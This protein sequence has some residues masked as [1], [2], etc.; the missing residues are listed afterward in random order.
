MTTEKGKTMIDRRSLFTAAAATVAV[1]STL[2]A[3]SAK[4]ASAAYDIEPRGA[5]GR[6]ERMPYLD[7]E[8]VHDYTAGVR[9]WHNQNISRAANARVKEI[10]KENGIDPSDTNLSVQ[11]VLALIEHDPIVAMSGRIWISNQQITWKAIADRFHADADKYLAEMESYDAIGPGTLEL[12]PDL[13]IPEFAKHQIHIQPGGYQGD[14]FAGHIYHIGT[15][16]FYHGAFPG[17][18]DQDQ[19]HAMATNN[20]PVP[21]DGKVK[22]ILDLGCGIGQQAVALKER[23]PNA[24]VWGLDVSGPMIR[25]G[26]MKAVDLGV[27]VN[28]VQRLAEDTKFPDNHFDIVSS[29]IMHH[30][31][32]AEITKAVFRE[33]HRITRPGGY[34]YPIDFRSA[35]Q[36][37]KRTA[38]RIYRSWWDHRWNNERWIMEFKSVAFEEEMEKVGFVLNPDAKPAIRGFGIR[39]GVKPA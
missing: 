21:D 39:H 14:P 2:G 31:L 34:Y 25:Y 4:A 24:E 7:L 28:F 12:N 22:R 20:L 10:F 15:N 37:P 23:F 18:N 30:E 11:E 35:R 26:H 3:G 36:A 9:S 38:Y 27:D 13:L 29:F 19:I 16:S 32:P 33:A 8:S 1:G 6:L 17:G 5:I